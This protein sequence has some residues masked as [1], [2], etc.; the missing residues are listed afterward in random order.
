MMIHIHRTTYHSLLKEKPAPPSTIPFSAIF[1]DIDEKW[2]T[3]MFIKANKTV[4][5]CLPNKTN[6]LTFRPFNLL[7]YG[8]NCCIGPKKGKDSRI[9]DLCDLG[10]NRY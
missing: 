4:V 7:S 9:G 10:D 8:A 1:K 2:G 6:Q 3:G 5:D